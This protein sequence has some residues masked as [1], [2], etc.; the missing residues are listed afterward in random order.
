MWTITEKTAADTLVPDLITIREDRFYIFDAK[1]Y[2][3]KLEQGQ[4]PKGQPGIESVTKQYLYQL[5][6]KKF[7]EK[8]GFASVENCFL[9]PIEEDMI[10]DKGSVRLEMLSELGLEDIKIRLVPAIMAYKHYLSGD[11]IDVRSVI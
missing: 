5:A 8:H 4:Y 2:K 10:I 6:Y 7:I 9:L 3:A 11:K 1:Y